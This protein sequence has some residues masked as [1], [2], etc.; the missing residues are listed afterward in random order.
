VA[1]TDITARKKAEAYLEFLGKHDVLTGLHNR[2]YYTDELSRLQRRG[3][4]PVSVLMLDL[5]GLKP[6]NDEHGHSAG[7]GLLRRIGEVLKQAVDKNHCAARIGGDEFVVLMGGTEA[8]AAQAL[9]DEIEKLIGLNNQFYGAP[10]LHVSYGIA[11]GWAGE[12][13]EDTIKRADAMLLEAKRH[14]YAVD[15]VDRRR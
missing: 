11:T 4:H 1:L 5:N 10:Q 14:Y 2:S 9:M 3:P 15:G 12:R 6:V 8:D 7:D 13:V